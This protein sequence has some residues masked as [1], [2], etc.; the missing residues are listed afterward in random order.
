[1]T[2]EELLPLWPSALARVLEEAHPFDIGALDDREYHGISLGQPQWVSRLTWVKFKKVF[3]RDPASGRLRGWN[4]RCEQTPL[5][6]PWT[7]RSRDEVRMTW[8]HY[9]VYSDEGEVTIDYGMGTRGLNPQRLIKDPLRA[10]NPGNPDLLIGV[11]RL[12][13]GVCSVGTPTYFALIRGGPL[14]YSVQP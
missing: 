7:D 4:V 9:G 11:S 14:Q 1:M 10:V 12:D 8:G 13:L 5:E 2:V 6:Q 3:F